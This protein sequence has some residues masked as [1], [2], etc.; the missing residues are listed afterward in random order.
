MEVLRGRLFHRVHLRKSSWKVRW[1][2]D[3]QVHAVWCTANLVCYAEQTKEIGRHYSGSLLVSVKHVRTCNIIG[4]CRLW[5]CSMDGCSIAYI[6]TRARGN[7]AHVHAVQRTASF[8]TSMLRRTNQRDWTAL[9]WILAFTSAN[10]MPINY[11]TTIV[12]T[13][14]TLLLWSGGGH[15]INFINIKCMSQVIYEPFAASLCEIMCV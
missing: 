7:D 14:T 4:S 6:Y 15:V 3:A 10:L 9:P 13:Y 12:T 5:R 1:Q 2:N 11:M 8:S